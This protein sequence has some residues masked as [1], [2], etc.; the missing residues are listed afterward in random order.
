M[1]CKWTGIE[2]S[3]KHFYNLENQH[4]PTQS[5]TQDRISMQHVH[6]QDVQ[7]VHV[8]VMNWETE[9]VKNWHERLELNIKCLKLK[10]AERERGRDEWG[11]RQK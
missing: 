8:A 1:F 11:W 7:H 3:R 4:K 2:G 6:V 9:D 5:G 10:Y